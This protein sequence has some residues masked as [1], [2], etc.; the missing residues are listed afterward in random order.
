MLSEK[1]LRQNT[2]RVCACLFSRETVLTNFYASHTGRREIHKPSWVPY[3]IT[4][5]LRWRTQFPI[6]RTAVVLLTLRRP[7]NAY[8]L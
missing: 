7:H 5:F 8:L 4:N 1:T 2:I 6:L 3:D